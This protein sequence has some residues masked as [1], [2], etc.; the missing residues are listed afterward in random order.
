MTL[1]DPLIMADN[2]VGAAAG[3]ALGLYLEEPHAGE[4]ANVVTIV[5]TISVSVSLF[6]KEPIIVLQL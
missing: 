2:T 3:R 1:P 4:L 6:S 5:L